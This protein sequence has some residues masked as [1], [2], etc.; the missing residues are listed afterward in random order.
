MEI[1]EY[2]KEKSDKKTDTAMNK[3]NNFLEKVIGGTIGKTIT[4]LSTILSI[5]LGVKEI[6]LVFLYQ[7]PQRIVSYYKISEN[8]PNKSFIIIYYILSVL[9]DI[10]HIEI[11]K[12][13]KQLKFFLLL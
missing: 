1:K 3:I 2:E 4:I 8:V 7:E 5:I 9:G 13:K 10:I 12:K 11:I 6:S